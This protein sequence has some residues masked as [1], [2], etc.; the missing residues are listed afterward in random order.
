LIEHIYEFLL[1]FH[2]NCPYLAPF[3]RYSEILVENRRLKLPPPLFGAAVGRDPVG[4]SWKFLVSE[5]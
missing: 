5:N 1:A 2:S 4:I 3:L